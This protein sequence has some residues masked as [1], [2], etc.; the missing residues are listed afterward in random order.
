MILE[1]LLSAHLKLSVKFADHRLKITT[2]V[3]GDH[4]EHRFLFIEGENQGRL[5]TSFMELRPDQRQYPLEWRSITSGIW[6]VTVTL[7]DA[8][9]KVVD[10]AHTAIVIP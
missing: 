7:G 5:N 6:D 8:D 3:D 4:P 2:T 10:R 1:L 9:G